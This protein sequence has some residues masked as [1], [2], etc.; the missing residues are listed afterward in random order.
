M[1]Y[2]II[3]NENTG[4]VTNTKPKVSKVAI[5]NFLVPTRSIL[6]LDEEFF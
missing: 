4:I 2:R 5:L 1:K 3:G 6:E